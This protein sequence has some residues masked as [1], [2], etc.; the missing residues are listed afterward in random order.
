MKIPI[1]QSDGQIL[2]HDNETHQV[3]DQPDDPIDAFAVEYIRH[4]LNKPKYSVF[5]FSSYMQQAEN[6]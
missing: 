1:F 4:Y 3:T 5:D 6:N 2:W